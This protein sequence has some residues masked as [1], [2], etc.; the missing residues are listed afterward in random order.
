MYLD[1]GRLPAEYKASK[2]NVMCQQYYFMVMP[3]LFYCRLWSRAICS[4]NIKLAHYQDNKQTTYTQRQTF[5]IKIYLYGTA[6][7]FCILTAILSICSS[8]PSVHRMVIANIS[9]FS[10]F[11]FMESPIYSMYLLLLLS[12]YLF[13]VLFFFFFLF[14][15]GVLLSIIIVILYYI[16]LYAFLFILSF[17]FS[18]E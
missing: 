15:S 17:S 10:L 5:N 12:S 13:F 1:T 16:L 3:G 7:I 2:R 14:K 6:N 4:N 8:V 11:C 9:N 18:S